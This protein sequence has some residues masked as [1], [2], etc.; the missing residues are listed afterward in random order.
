MSND[1]FMRQNVGMIVIV[2][3]ANGPNFSSGHDLGSDVQVYIYFI[4]CGSAHDCIEVK[5]RRLLV[6]AC[7]LI[8]FFFTQVKDLKERN[9][10]PGPL[11]D[12]EK[13]SEMDTEMCLKWRQ[14]PKP[15]VCGVKG[16]LFIKYRN[17]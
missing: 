7:I 12:F 17:L 16:R 5:K 15:V 11:G 10:Y 4:S 13:W 6:Y 2:L 14:I 3:R 1:L 8:L 9:Y